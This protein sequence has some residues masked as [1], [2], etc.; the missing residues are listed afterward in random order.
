[1]NNDEKI[2]C[3]KNIL[4]WKYIYSIGSETYRKDNYGRK[5]PEF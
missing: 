5:K 3:L 1:M 2:I 4:I